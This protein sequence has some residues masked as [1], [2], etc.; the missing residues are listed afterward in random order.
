MAR[1]REFGKVVADRSR[2]IAGDAYTRSRTNEPDA[3]ASQSPRPGLL[4]R[5]VGRLPDGVRDA[6]RDALGPDPKI[7]R[8]RSLLSSARRQMN[9]VRH[10]E[11]A[12]E[13]SRKVLAQREKRLEAGLLELTGRE[14][15]ADRLLAQARR[16]AQSASAERRIE[17]DRIHV[18]ASKNPRPIRGVKRLA[19][20][21]K[22]FG[23]LTPMVVRPQG[24]DFELVTGYRRL[25]ALKASDHT[26]GVVRVVDNLDER[27]AAALYA[28]ENCLV[29][30]MSPNAIRNLGSRVTDRPEFSAVIDLIER[31]DD[32]VVEEV[33]LE[34]MV[35]DAQHHLNEGAAWVATLRPYWSEIEKAD[36][37][38]LEDLIFYF[39][40][41]SKRL[42][43]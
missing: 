27:T 4:E 37:K 3:S 16:A 24:D 35:E 40:R 25:A 43:R 31:D 41:L 29:D 15:E 6:L 12:L 39:A 18:D 22:R 9:D 7:E 26:H 19:A 1:S 10:R 30:G 33:F 11:A 36:Q 17:L 38:T 14:R 13:A 5:L 34:D 23:Q 8:G 20:N 32:S 21:I 2:R 28:A 42:S